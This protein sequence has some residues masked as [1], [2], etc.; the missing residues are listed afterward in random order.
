M[1]TTE[2]AAEIVTVMDL[3]EVKFAQRCTNLVNSSMLVNSYPKAEEKLSLRGD[4]SNYN[5]SKHVNCKHKE[6]KIPPSLYT[7]PD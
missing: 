4:F 7:V 2:L 1:T 3:Y 5:I 6:G